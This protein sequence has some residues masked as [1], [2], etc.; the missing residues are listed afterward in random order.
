MSKENRTDSEI[1]AVEN[2][3]VV[4]GWKRQSVLWEDPKTQSLHTLES[5]IDVLCD[6]EDRERS[7]SITSP[8]GALTRREKN[9]LGFLITWSLDGPEQGMCSV[10]D[11][12]RMVVE[13]EDYLKTQEIYISGMTT[14]GARTGLSTP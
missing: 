14:H 3:L 8:L 2:A 13:L 6:R 5:A 4:R 11:R 9:R 10:A 1:K 12:N 7:D